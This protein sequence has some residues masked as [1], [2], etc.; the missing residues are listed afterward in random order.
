METMSSNSSDS[1]GSPRPKWRRPQER[2]FCVVRP[3]YKT[4][5]LFLACVVLGL[6]ISTLYPAHDGEAGEVVEHLRSGAG[7]DPAMVGKDHEPSQSDDLTA[8]DRSHVSGSMVGYGKHSK[9]KSGGP[10]GDVYKK[11]SNRLATLKPWKSSSGH[12]TEEL[13]E[14]QYSSG[15]G[16]EAIGE[17]SR[18]AKITINTGSDDAEIY[19]RAL[20]THAAHNKLHNYPMFTLRNNIMEKDGVWSKPA[21]ILSVMLRELAKPRSGRLQ[22]LLWVDADTVILNPKIPLDILLP[23]AGWTDVNM[24]VTE[25]FNGLNNGVFPIRVCSW[26]V[27]LLTAV[28]SF[29]QYRPDKDLKFRDQTAMAE[30]LKEPRFKRHTMKPPQRWFNGY[31]GELNDTL[32]PYQIRRGDLLVHFAGF[33]DREERM[34]YWLDRAEQHD[35]DWELDLKQTTYPPEVKDFWKQSGKARKQAQ[36]DDE[37]TQENAQSLINDIDTWKSK[38]PDVVTS[39]L[40]NDINNQV[41]NVRQYIGGDGFKDRPEEFVKAVEDL[42]TVSHNP[43]ASSTYESLLLTGL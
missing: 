3:T 39:E 13:C 26:S 6:S 22:W 9:S 42:R 16:D 41:A 24:L 40:K 4:W 18:I 10:L 19:E 35:P 27:E 38:Y 21:Y 15:Q 20:R 28:M 32:A 14:E 30:L 7:F 2:R 29:P 43:R 5:I 23:P 36:K 25:D 34:A 12:V 37:K 1:D 11:F 8:L 33:T 17:N 31:P